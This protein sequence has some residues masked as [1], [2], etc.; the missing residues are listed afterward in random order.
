MPPFSFEAGTRALPPFISLAL[1]SF[2]F[3]LAMAFAF[4]KQKLL[5]SCLWFI[6]LEWSN[7]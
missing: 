7:D 6:S 4:W 5:L 2:Y 1:V 3:C